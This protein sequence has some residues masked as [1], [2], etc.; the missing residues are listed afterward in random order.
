MRYEDK[1]YIR[2]K[3]RAEPWLFQIPGVYVVGLGPNMKAGEFSG[4]PAILAF[5]KNKMPL[6]ILGPQ[7]IIP[8]KIEG[9]H[10]VVIEGGAA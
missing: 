5:V 8:L 9:I 7:E 2:V 1:F 4:E 3:N 6:D 10:T